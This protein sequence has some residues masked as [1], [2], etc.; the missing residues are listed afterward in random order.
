M[1]DFTQK[2]WKNIYSNLMLLLCFSYHDWF[3]HLILLE[4]ILQIYV[5]F[6]CF[7]ISFMGFFPKTLDPYKA[8]ANKYHVSIILSF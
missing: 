8:S 2:S 1:F 4:N 3:E 5:C 7:A 6:F